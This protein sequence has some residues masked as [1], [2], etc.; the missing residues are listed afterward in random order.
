MLVAV[1]QTRGE[2][3]V[4]Y[5]LDSTATDNPHRASS[6][7]WCRIKLPDLRDGYLSEVYTAPSYRG[8]LG[9]PICSS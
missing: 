5:N 7:R 3:L 4:N 1:C 8:G 9:L 2:E 6:A